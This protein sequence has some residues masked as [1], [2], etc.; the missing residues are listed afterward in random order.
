M[1]TYWDL[2]EAARAKLTREDVEK[3]EAVEL[4]KKG[5]LK[6]PAEPELEPVPARPAPAVA[7]ALAHVHRFGEGLEPSDVVFF[8]AAPAKALVA[9]GAFVL[10]TDYELGHKAKVARP[11]IAVKELLVYTEEQARESR[12]ILAEAKAAEERNERAL[13]RHKAAVSKEREALQG[14]W[15]DWRECCAKG[16]ELQAI[17]DTFQRYKDLAGDVDVAAKFLREAFS[18]DEIAEAATWFDLH[19]PGA[20]PVAAE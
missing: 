15:A 17:V 18:R 3:L 1:Q 9:A 14:M 12:K 2:S 11:V 13:E 5:V 10:T 8:D 19:I 20:E 6:A 7:F 4:M 16:R